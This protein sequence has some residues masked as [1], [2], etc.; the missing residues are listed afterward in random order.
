M[1]A[2]SPTPRR[3]PELISF[4]DFTYGRYDNFFVPTFGDNP[5]GSVRFPWRFGMNARLN[6]PSTIFYVGV[7]LNKGTGPDSMSIFVG[8]RADLSAMLGKLIP[9]AQH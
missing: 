4:I 3:A 8:A 5:N 2:L 9:S 7:D 1:F 6:I